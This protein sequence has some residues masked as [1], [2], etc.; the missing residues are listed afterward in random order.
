MDAGGAISQAD[1]T[2]AP[3][4]GN[5]YGPLL[6]AM[7][8]VALLSVP[9]ID[10]GLS[11]LFY[12]AGA[13]FAGDHVAF[14]EFIRAAVPPMILGSLLFVVLLWMSGLIGGAWIWNISTRPV[15]YLLATVLIGPGLLVETLLKPHWG[16]AR[17]KDVTLFGGHAVYTPPFMMSD[18]CA[19]NC[20]FVSGHAAIAFWLTAY[21][22]LLPT[23][24]RTPGLWLAAGFGLFVGLVRVLQGAHFASD[25][26]AAGLIV[27][28]VNVFLARLILKPS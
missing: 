20:S 23:S 9:G 13:G 22:F 18:Q 24:W 14:F 10:Q 5:A 8:L 15:V 12:R 27:M 1:D 17:P 16:R 11:R 7:A 4:I 3:T 26:A 21:A 25:V 6:A 28:S 19:H 2:P